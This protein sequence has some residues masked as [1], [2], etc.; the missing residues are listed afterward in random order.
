[1][2]VAIGVDSHKA[3]VGVGIVDGVGSDRGA[4][5]FGND[6]RGHRALLEWI[7]AQGESRIIGIE[8]AGNYGAG[9]A[10]FLIAAG[11]SVV[12]VPAFLTYRE[13]KRTPSQGKSDTSDALAIARVVARGEG[14]AQVSQAQ[15]LDDLKLLSDHRDQLVRARTKLANQTH[16]DLAILCPGYQV[17]VPNL[18]TKKNLAG[19]VIIVRA[20]RSVR[21]GLVRDRIAELRRIDHRIAEVTKWLAAKVIESGTTLTKLKGIGFVLAAKI[22]GEV[23]DI[24]RIRSE[25]AFAMFNGTAPLQAS[26]GSTNRHRLNRGGNRQLNSALHM[27]ATTLC[28]CEADTKAYVARRMTEGKTRKEAMRCLKRHLSN[29]VYRRL[30]ADESGIRIAA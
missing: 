8:G 1:M 13:R 14:L 20:D 23:G 9:L 6:D 24:A 28:R 30:L 19:A 29:V 15:V 17:R 4:Q 5:E 26:S 2:D 12:E 16:S 10:R 21:A 22:L 11:E 3:S 25:A 18:T 7:R 27:V